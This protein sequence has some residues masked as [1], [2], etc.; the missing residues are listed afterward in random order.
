MR[1][2]R[3]GLVELHGHAW[4]HSGVAW[5]VAQERAGGFVDAVVDLDRAEL[6]P[7]LLPHADKTGRGGQQRDTHG[8]QLQFVVSL[9]P[10]READGI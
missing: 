3:P 9:S 6:L 8:H 7:P 10:P 4:L 5:E 2:A 1:L